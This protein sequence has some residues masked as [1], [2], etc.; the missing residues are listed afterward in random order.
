[1]TEADDDMDAALWAAGG[2]TEAERAALRERLKGDADFAAKAQAWE[3]MLAPLSAFAPSV[4]PPDGLLQK[5]E[6][7]IEARARLEMLSRTLRAS[8]GD[9]IKVAPGVRIK[10]LSH[11]PDEGR[12]TVLLDVEPGALYPAH[13]HEQDE[14]IYMIS[15]DLTI[16]A[17]TLGPGDFHV[18]PKGSRHAAATSRAGCRCLVTMAMS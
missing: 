17:E 15:G 10:L 1:M 14:E 16:G 8:E 18:S 13:A 2:L 11:R 9:W 7:R 12:Q 3:E 5:I 4:A 6:G